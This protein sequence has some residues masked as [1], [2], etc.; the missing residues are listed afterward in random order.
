[1]SEER[2]TYAF[3]PLERR[4]LLGPVRGGQ[5]LILSLGVLVAIAVLDRF[6]SAAGALAA[7]TSLAGACAASFAPLAGRTVQEWLPVGI[8]FLG[9]RLLGHWRFRS[10]TP[11][12]GT[13]ISIRTGWPRTG[14]RPHDPAV[15]PELR[16]LRITEVPYGGHAVGVLAEH[17]G[18][19]LT[20]VLACR[21]LAFSLLDPEAQERRLARWG[22]VLSSTAGTPVRRLQWIERTAPAQGDELARWLHSERDPALAPR[23]A[24]IME[25][26][27]ELIG[28]ST[29]I[30]QEHEILLAVQVDGR[31]SRNWSGRLARGLDE[32]LIE[33]TERVSRGLI[34][35]E[36]EVLGALSPGQL[37]RTLRTAFDPFARAELSGLEATDPDRDGLDEAEAWPVGARE[38]WDH[39]QSDGALH[40]SFWVSGWPRIEVS[41]MFM[42]ALLGRSGAVRAVAVTFEP[43][44]IGRSTREIEAAITRDQADRELRHRFGQSETAR[45]RQARTATR[46]REAELAAGHG[47]VRL[48]GFITVSGRDAAELRR[49]C[50]EVQDHAAR[51][52]LELHRLYGQQADAFTFTLPLCRGLR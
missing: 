9:R 28:A 16:G 19:R 8:S 37:A 38:R 40:A 25:S 7:L 30:T 11:T 35:A 44:A 22:L 23:G 31:R 21:V 10:P 50:A 15:P 13:F 51:A 33:V 48:S 29:R 52:R 4:G 5:A 17:A 39:Y 3:G 45:Q 36:V 27:L 14:R 20:A 1:M 47:E 42:D 6:S 24:P 49:S 34:E 18:R 46:R 12:A 26:Y 41:P 43:L 32:Q 2:L